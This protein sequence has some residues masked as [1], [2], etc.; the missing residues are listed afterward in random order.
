M[1]KSAK[2]KIRI[3]NYWTQTKPDSKPQIA[4][5]LIKWKKV[6]SIIRTPTG[7]VHF[8]MKGVLAPERWSTLAI[9]VTASKYFRKK[10]VPKT[11]AEKSVLQLV[12]RVV[13]ALGTA[14]VRQK[15][16]SKKESLHFENELKYIL[17]T[18]RA[19]F[20]SPVW[21]NVGLQQYKLKSPSQHW[22]LDFKKKKVCLI[23][24]AYQRPQA[25][26]CF[27][28]SVDDS[29]EGIFE[30][31]KTEARLF[32]YGSGSGTNFSTLRSKYEELTSGGTSSGLM[33]FLE[34]LDRG[35]GAIKSGG[36]TRRAAKM[37]ILDVDHPEIEDF[38][39]WKVAEE[40]KAHLLIQAGMSPDFEGPAYKTISGQNANNSIRV[41]DSFMKAVIQGQT[42]NLKS[43]TEGVVIKKIPAV[44]IWNKISSAA[45]FC[46]DPGLQFDDTINAWNTC[47]NDERIRA[48]NPCSEF[49]FLDNTACNLASLN[50]AAFYDS[51]TGFDLKG[52]LHTIKIIFLAQD[53]LVDEA[54]YPTEKIAQ[55]SH[56]YRPLGIGFAN[57]GSLLMKMGIPYDSEKGRLWASLL[58]SLL[59]AQAYLTSS[60][61]AEVKD[62]FSKFK[63]NKKSVL[64][65]LNKHRSAHRSIK[66]KI[67]SYEPDK[68]TPQTLSLFFEQGQ[69]LW[70]QVL[71]QATKNGIRNSQASAIAPTGTIGL[72]MDCD[73]TGIEPE[74]SLVKIK[75]L[76]GGGTFQM[77]SQSVSSALRKLGY[78]EDQII[79]I[80]QKISEGQDV[81]DIEE[82]SLEARDV[83]ACAMGKKPLSAE[84][85]LM[86]MAAV[87]P[88]ISGAISK[89]I[90]LPKSCTVAQVQEVYMKA[91]KL[92]LKSVALYRDGSKMSQPLNKMSEIPEGFKK[93][94]ECGGP[95]EL[96]S[97][98]YRCSNC[99]F[100]LG[101]A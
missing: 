26:A 48:S 51:K 53:V 7:Q 6:D 94:P 5:K 83:L 3:L 65:V 35:A 101:C 27:I 95:T 100:S 57:L 59:T 43:R 40:K 42:W 46:A 31:A 98:C 34:V 91:W 37:V 10:G 25:S 72:M 32:K 50:L 17:L 14:A 99:G 23:T 96:H 58:S 67:Q 79:K 61:L 52:Y 4:E 12:Q 38:I 77:A 97:G 11:G 82:L 63:K 45:W 66:S 70:D 29:I 54:S 81:S 28:Q 68:N 64:R 16:L 85:H 24:D 93:C 9:D 87:Q 20:N 44:H 89:T 21:F 74:F 30:L 90:N 78:P 1:K 76:V 60:E 18:Q 69:T 88:F 80:E 84:S 62:S 36:T 56:D 19:A 22:A 47:A 39:D 8:Q 86:M 73:T 13:T 75:K 15:Y 71:Q 49:M 41:S 33:S 55:R 2:A 92:G